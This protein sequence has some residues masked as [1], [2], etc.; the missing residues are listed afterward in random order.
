MLLPGSERI[1]SRSR[2]RTL[3]GKWDSPKSP[4]G[5]CRAVAD[6]DFQIRGG[7]V[8]NLIFLRASVWTKYNGG[9]SVD[10]PLTG[11]ENGFQEK[12]DRSSG[13]G[14]VAKKGLE[15]GLRTPSSPPPASLQTLSYL[16][17]FISS[18]LANKSN[19]SFTH[20]NDNKNNKLYLDLTYN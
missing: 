11:K 13:Y 12:G 9:P 5:Y 19:I 7:A 6:P 18:T 4:Q 20:I 16:P 1:F 8:S 17:Y 10:P 3:L 14:L 2:I 15:C